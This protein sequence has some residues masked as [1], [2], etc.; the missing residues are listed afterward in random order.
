MADDTGNAEIQV[1]ARDGVAVVTLTR[2]SLSASVKKA[3]RGALADV[4]ADET[5]RAVVLTGTG[6]AFCVGQDLAE[7]A[8]ALETDPGMAFVTLDED[9]DRIVTALATMPKPVVAA[10][11]GTCVGAGL[12]FALACDVRIA[13]ES[14]ASARPSPGSA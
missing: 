7:H 12:G 10:I 11:N 1:G 8:V 13:A 9:Y 14:G 2:P 3:L 5:V 6:N 4:A